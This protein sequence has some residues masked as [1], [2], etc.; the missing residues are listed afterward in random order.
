M[1]SISE[2]KIC[3]IPKSSKLKQYSLCSNLQSLNQD[4]LVTHKICLS[5]YTS[6]TRIDKHLKRKLSS[7]SCSRDL[8]SPKRQ[9]RSEV[10]KIKWLKHCICGDD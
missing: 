4:N 2:K 5:T 3:S 1:Q 6:K 9:R 8:L 7:Q 10:P